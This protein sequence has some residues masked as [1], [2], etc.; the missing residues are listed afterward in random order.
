MLIKLFLWSLLLAFFLAK[1]EINIEGQSGWAK[2]LPTWRIKNKLTK[3]FLGETPLTGYHTWLFGMMF[4]LYHFPF[5]VGVDWSL[6]LELQFIA[7]FLFFSVTED[8]LWFI[9][10]PNF[11][12]K[13]FRKNYVPWHKIWIGP[14][15]RNYIFVVT[16]VILIL[17]LSF[18]I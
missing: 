10:N 11:G 4:V 7:A 14:I 1:L 15:P 8:F 2:N 12:I 9:L 3:F 6:Q 13:K 16:A 18:S 5:V 17:S